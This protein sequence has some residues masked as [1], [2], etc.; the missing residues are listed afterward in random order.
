MAGEADLAAYFSAFGDIPGIGGVGQDFS[1]D[2]GFYAAF[3]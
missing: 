3:F 1:L 2:E